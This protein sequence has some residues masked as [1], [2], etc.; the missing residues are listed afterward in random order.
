METKS[1]Q[2]KFQWWNSVTDDVIAIKCSDERMKKKLIFSNK[3]LAANV[4]VFDKMVDLMNQR[5]SNNER[6][7]WLSFSQKQNKFKALVSECRSTSQ[8]QR[9][10]LKVSIY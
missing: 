9:T 5:A 10:V 4:N 1:S 8:T 3:K 2:K 7:Y 6:K